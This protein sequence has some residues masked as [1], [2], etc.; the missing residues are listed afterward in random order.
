M[1]TD[2]PAAPRRLPALGSTSARTGRIPSACP[3]TCP[4]LRGPCRGRRRSTENRVVSAPGFSARRA[5]A[6]HRPCTRPS[7]RCTRP[8][9]CHIVVLRAA[10]AGIP[11]APVILDPDGA[12][13]RGVH[14][15]GERGRHGGPSRTATTLFPSEA[16][17]TTPSSPFG[18]DTAGQ[19]GCQP[20]SGRD[21]T[22]A[23]RRVEAPLDISSSWVGAVEREPRRESWRSSRR[24][25]VPTRHIR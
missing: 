3:A 11:P 20:E 23:G 18:P 19:G 10:V 8:R 14:G 7:S 22:P 9:A 6:G 12:Q 5:P 2:L 15:D 25:A 13:N 24:D 1:F 16:E 17:R 4:P 21:C